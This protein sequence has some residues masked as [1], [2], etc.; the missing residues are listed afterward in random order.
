[1]YVI[2]IQVHQK[3]A[4]DS[5]IYN[6]GMK[7]NMRMSFAVVYSPIE[8]GFYTQVEKLLGEKGSL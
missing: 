8:T 5:I 4:R 2:F 7:I 1:M 3:N 6:L